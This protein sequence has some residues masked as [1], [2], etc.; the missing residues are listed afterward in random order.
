MIANQSIQ[1]M[2]TDKARNNI[3]D[4]VGSGAPT[5]GTSGTGVGIC[6]KGSLY[7]DYTNGNVYVNTGTISS[8]T[9]TRMGGAS[10]AVLASPVLSGTVTGTY[11]LGGTPTITSP[12]ITG[13]PNINVL[14]SNFSTAQ[15]AGAFASD[16]YLV[17]SSI[18]VPTGGWVAGARYY[19]MFDM[20]KTGAGT[21]QFTITLRIG[22][23]GS[24]ADTAI[25]S[26]AFAA[27]TA[28]IDSGIF[29]VWAHFRTV[30]AGTSAVVVGEAVCSHALAATGLIS[31]GASGNGQLNVVSSG[32]DST[33]ANTILGL[34][35]NGGASFSGTNT[36][37]EAEY[38]GF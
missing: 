27:G 11:T 5:N 21:A 8:P 35:I 19:C 32:F 2:L 23:N 6:G 3:F 24:T 20:V 26:F 29:E 1:A 36:I 15:V 13:T 14:K 12:I 4:T 34:S 28:A 30:G 17:G 25:C 38:H 16:T 31:T 18:P 33:T 37:V 22:I 7:A 9:W 10:G